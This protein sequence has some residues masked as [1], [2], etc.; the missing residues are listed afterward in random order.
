MIASKHLS[1]T[2]N[3]ISLLSSGLGNPYTL[4]CIE[5]CVFGLTISLLRGNKYY[6]LAGGGGDVG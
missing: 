6:L 1:L 2:E 3:S 4:I 5:I